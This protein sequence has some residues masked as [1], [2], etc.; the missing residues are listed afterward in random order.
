MRS[1]AGQGGGASR[2]PLPK[3]GRPGLGQSWSQASP[4][5]VPAGDSAAEA[6][7]QDPLH[8]LGWRPQGG[9]VTLA[10]PTPTCWCCDSELNLVVRRVG[11]ESRRVLGPESCWPVAEAPAS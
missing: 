11:A 4:G 6:A 8:G 1:G 9:V 7:T 3:P 5:L 10:L 2:W